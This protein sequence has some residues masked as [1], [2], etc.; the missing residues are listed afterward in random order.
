MGISHR[1]TVRG[2]IGQGL[3]SLE[4]N[5]WLTRCLIR[6]NAAVNT[7]FWLELK[8]PQNLTKKSRNDYVN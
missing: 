3:A 5:H 6:L 7:R 4:T 8:D 2:K 1:G